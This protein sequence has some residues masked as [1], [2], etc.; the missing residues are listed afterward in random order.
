[1]LCGLGVGPKSR[2]ELG[3]IVTGEFN[4]GKDRKITAWH[5]ATS[6]A[7]G[8]VRRFSTLSL[9]LPHFL[10]CFSFLSMFFL[11]PLFAYPPNFNYGFGQ[12]VSQ[13]NRSN[14]LDGKTG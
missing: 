11:E 9:I 13:C 4:K 7:L 3:S 1:M 2:Q 12:L 10:P 6:S 5:Y 8:G 14:F